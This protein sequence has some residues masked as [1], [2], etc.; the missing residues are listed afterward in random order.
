MQDAPKAV[1]P[2]A[3]D[4][5][6]WDIVKATQYGILPRIVE[7]VEPPTGS[8]NAPANVNKLDREGVSLLHW[9][10]INNKFDVVKYLISKGAEVDR[11]GGNQQASPM[12]WAIREYHL[13]MVGLLMYYGADP[14][15]TDMFGMTCLHVAAQ[16]GAT[17]ILLYLLAKGIEV[18]WWVFPRTL[19][20]WHFL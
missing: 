11:V 13:E 20:W 5:S 8:N 14:H 4:Y 1:Q 18:D 9:A 12:H 3:D 19:F 16:M 15:V 2:H 6:T 17:S 7:L 10:A